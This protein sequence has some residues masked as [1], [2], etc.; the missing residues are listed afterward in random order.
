MGSLGKNERNKDRKIPPLPLRRVTSDCLFDNCLLY[1]PIYAAYI[2][3]FSY[4]TQ[5]WRIQG[6]MPGKETAQKQSHPPVS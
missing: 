4:S 2:P 3:Y 5:H 6:P 1:A